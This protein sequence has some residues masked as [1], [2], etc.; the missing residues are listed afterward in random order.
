MQ[1]DGTE[2]RKEHSL[3]STP[4]HCYTSCQQRNTK[5]T[6]GYANPNAAFPVGKR[7]FCT[8]VQNYIRN[9]Q[10]CNVLAGNAFVF[11]STRFCEGVSDLKIN[12][13]LSLESAYAFWRIL[14]AMKKKLHAA[15][16]A[17]RFIICSV[18][19]VTGDADSL[20]T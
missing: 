6:G 15:S 5:A 16:V 18:A 2:N 3:Y 13:T 14:Y 19:P 9:I 1:Q 20:I 10:E 11:I 4:A 12:N 17:I 7:W 8:L